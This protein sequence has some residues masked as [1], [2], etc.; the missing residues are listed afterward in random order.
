MPSLRSLAALA[1]VFCSYL[2]PPSSMRINDFPLFFMFGILLDG[3][4][5]PTSMPKTL[6]KIYLTPPKIHAKTSQNRPQYAPKARSGGGCDLS[7]VFVGFWA[8]HGGV[9]GPSWG[10]LGPSWGRLG[11]VWE[12][13]GSV[14]A[15]SLGVWELSWGVLGASW[16]RLGA[17]F[18]ANST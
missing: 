17:H 12:R 9:L 16:G 10:V 4:K 14:L 1:L 11:A 3:E 7:C 18:I 8:P 13:P 5:I 15:A 6:R 2:S